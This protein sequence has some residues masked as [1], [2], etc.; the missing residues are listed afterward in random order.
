MIEINLL[1]ERFRKK[2]KGLAISFPQLP[3]E[4]LILF[5]GG[6]LCLLILIHILLVGVLIIQRVRLSSLNRGWQKIMP[7]KTQ[8]DGVKE[9]IAK[10]E[11]RLRSFDAATDPSKRIIWAKKLNQL[12]DFLPGGVWLTKLSFLN[13][14]FIIEGSAISK[15]GE[16]MVMV[17]KFTSALKDDPVFTRD[18]KDIELTSINRRLIKSVEVADF[19]ITVIL[20]D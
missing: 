11:N 17:G 12:S 6:I 13:E 5:I 15:K 9:E 18:F 19:V 1:P 20:K 16:E 4:A 7:A 8:V 3:R 10:I 2:K 14:R